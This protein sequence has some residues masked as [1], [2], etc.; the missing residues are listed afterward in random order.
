MKHILG[1]LFIFALSSQNFA[2]D[3]NAF[4][5]YNGKGKKVKYKKM[6][7]ALKSNSIV[8]YGEY[9]DDPISHWLEYEITELLF[10][11]YGDKFQIGMEMFERDQQL[12]LNKYL[13]NELK[14]RQFEELK[15]WVNYT[16]DYKPI[17]VFAKNNTIPVIATNAPTEIARKVY[18]EG[19]EVLKELEPERKA[20]V[21]SEDYFIDTTLSQ[22]NDLL[23]MGVHGNDLNT[24]LLEA[25][26]LKDATMAESILNVYQPDGCI[27]HIN[28]AFHSDYFQGISWYVKQVKPEATILSISTVQQV[29]VSHLNEEHIG[30]ADFI[31]CVTE[32]MTKTH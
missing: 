15:L 3:G 7:K 17:V 6:V 30:K 31:I 8:F 22:Y 14:D 23:H 13:N 26:A 27:L 28:G 21:C 4:Q 29:D 9:H 12:S 19:R 10:S 20:M 24:N 18:H 25:Q 32:N 2:Q 5:I 1:I 11:Q 16:T